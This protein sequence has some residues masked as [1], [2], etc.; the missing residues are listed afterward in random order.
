MDLGLANR[1]AVVAGASKGIG[2]AIALQLAQEGVDVVVASRT[3]SELEKAAQEIEAE[4]GR[5]VVPITFDA[6]QREQV[7]SMM[8]KASDALG[9]IHSSSTAPPIPA[10]P[11]TPRDPSTL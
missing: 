2:K 4:T 6:T 8:A 1:H 10:V 11:P 9:G 3:M 7:D 5:R